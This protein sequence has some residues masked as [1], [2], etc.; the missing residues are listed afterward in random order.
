[1]YTPQT[2][3][4]KFTLNQI[5]GLDE[6]LAGGVFGD[7]SGDLVDAILSE[8]GRF[9]AD[10]IA[11]LNRAGDE[12][13]CKLD[14]ETHSVT[15]APG[16][17][18]AYTQWCEAGWPALP[19]PVEFGGQGL[20]VMVSLA[21]QEL[22]NTAASAYGIGTLLTQGAIN[23]LKSHG[24]DE[25]KEKFLP[26]MVSGRWTGTMCLTEPQAGTDLGAL[27]TRAEPAGDGSYRIS[28]TKIFIT[29][30]EHDLTENIIHLVL[31]RLPGAPEGH[32]GISLFVVPKFMVGDDGSIG[33]RNDVKCIGIEHKMGI[34]GSPTATLQ[35]GD[36][37]GATGFL[38]GEENRG[39]NCMFTMMNDAR[40]HVGM[41]GV[42][43]AERA[44]QQAL[45]YALE[46][47]QGSKPGHDGS[48]AI[49]EHADVRRMLLD[50]KST[51]AA[52]RASC[53]LCARALDLSEHAQDE[54][55]RASSAALAALLTP[56]AKAYGTDTGMAVASAGIQ[57]H[58]GMGYIEETGAAQHLRDV[59]ITQIYE[60]T[61]GIQALDL[62]TRKLPLG[63]GA[64]VNGWLDELENIA[65][66]LDG[67][68]APVGAEL[69]GAITAIRQATGWLLQRLG[70][71]DE[72]AVASAPNYLHAL[73]LATGTAALARGVL[74]GSDVPGHDGRV[75][76]LNYYA[77]N[78]LPH[79]GALT[80]IVME[81][82]AAIIDK[83]ADALV[84]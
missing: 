66:R 82:S 8:A 67:D 80:R 19:C 44:F 21:V 2:E 7:L 33:Q 16:W 75:Q 40:L 84:I 53:Y 61:N 59:R 3:D 27:K 77:F 56:I 11:P 24:A 52:A 13:G 71:R 36:E 35:F 79:A 17:R 38:V 64:V 45:A 73:A 28:G 57:V 76:L 23:A 32:R 9:A 47:T 30:G 43:V 29:Y 31:A 15:T 51:T 10:I 39:L 58:G 1:M 68:L 50:M 74:A 20:P 12:H 14:P 25:L 6:L 65:R 62:V 55:D 81:G 72:R 48:V 4:L 41:Q 26:N 60:G 5:A 46:R 34:H 37:G 18:E 42:A 63:N 83:S 54:D 70:E 22:W 78:R 49:I 69:S